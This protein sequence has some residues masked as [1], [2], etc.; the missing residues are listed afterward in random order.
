[1]RERRAESTTAQFGMRNKQILVRKMDRTTYWGYSLSWYNLAGERAKWW[2]QIKERN[3]RRGKKE[4]KRKRENKEENK[5]TFYILQG[6]FCRQPSIALGPPSGDRLWVR[7]TLFFLFPTSIP[8]SSKCSQSTVKGKRYIVRFILCFF[9]FIYSR[10][11]IRHFPGI[12]KMNLW[13]EKKQ[14]T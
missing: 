13:L 11:L 4:T 14:C 3:K 6:T 9:V 7:I 2:D 10:D 5:K 1:M 8:C 12:Y